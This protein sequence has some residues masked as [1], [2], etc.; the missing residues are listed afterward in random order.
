MSMPIETEEDLIAEGKAVEGIGF[1]TNFGLK[2]SPDRVKRWRDRWQPQ[3][4]AVVRIASETHGGWEARSGAVSRAGRLQFIYLKRDGEQ[5]FTAGLFTIP[6]LA[7][8][9]EIR[10]LVSQHRPDDYERET[11]GAQFVTWVPGHVE[12]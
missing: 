7:T 11:V 3:M 8:E 9:D 4:D 12:A 1:D 6:Y 10:A 5:R 2:P